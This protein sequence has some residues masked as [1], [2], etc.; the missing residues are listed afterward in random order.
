MIPIFSSSYSIGKS[1]FQIKEPKS[2]DL[3]TTSPV[4]IF[5][6][7]S[8]L[9]DIY[10][11]DNSMIGFP[12]AF[13]IAEKLGKNL[14]FGLMVSTKM[15]DSN[16]EHYVN[17]SK[18]IAFAKNDQ[19]FNDL[20]KFHHASQ[21]SPQPFEDL[22]KFITDNIFIAIP[23]YDS[24]LHVNA[25]NFSCQI[26]NLKDVEHLFWCENHGLP[27]DHILR[28]NLIKYY[29]ENKPRVEKVFSIFYNAK[30]DVSDYQVHRCIC[31]RS[32][33]R[34]KKLTL[35]NPNLNHFGS[36]LFSWEAFCEQSS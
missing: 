8:S 4:S 34:G 28:E 17:H 11:V 30:K 13:K 21:P 15:G 26:P 33:A 16:E 25:M 5:D 6:L 2:D 36:D 35:S 29:N 32:R 20:L 9:D 27:F 23:F 14:H 19:G 1:I 7:S 22:K 3:D 24:F 31:D 18:I 12:F 10:L